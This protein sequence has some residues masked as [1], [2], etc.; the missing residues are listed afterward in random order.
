[1]TDVRKIKSLVDEVYATHEGYIST[2][3]EGCYRYHAGCLAV[4][5]KRIL[6]D[7]DD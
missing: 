2:H 4:V 5:I 3:Y 1:M 7:G 6:E